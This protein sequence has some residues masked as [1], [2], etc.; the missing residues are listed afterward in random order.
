MSR[1]RYAIIGFPLKHSFSPFI[2]NRA[3][4]DLK[5]N[6]QYEKIEILPEQ[7]EQEMVRLKHANIAG[8]NVTIPFK[9]RI[10]PYVDYLSPDAGEI[11]AVNT[12]KR[13]D[14]QWQGFNTDWIGFLK[15]L[16]AQAN[17]IESCLMLGA[18]GAARGVLYALL[19]LTGLQTILIANRTPQR[20][21]ELMRGFT[22]VN[23][24]N[25]EVIDLER[26]K[27]LQKQFD[28]IVNTTSVGMLG[29]E[30]GPL[31]DPLKI[32]HSQTLVYDLIYNPPNT[33]LLE[34]AGQAGL[35]IINGLP[36]LIFQ[37]EAACKIWT[38]YKYPERTLQFLFETLP[39]LSR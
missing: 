20:A 32:A 34:R 22:A 33:P 24:V 14:G 6:A 1:Q 17:E 39:D 2:H 35:K 9:E 15:P 16:E 36:M 25:I 10:L 27:T 4:N 23:K 29:H 21:K 11:G 13:V 18:G 37:A 3:F 31:V 28:L 5:I 19:Q 7:F 38:G 12:V 26:L 8:F 30:A